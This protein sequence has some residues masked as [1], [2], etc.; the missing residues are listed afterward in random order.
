M[1]ALGRL[2][3]AALAG[4]L[5]RDEVAAEI[6]RQL[7]AFEAAWGSGPDFVDGHQ[8]VHVLPGV[9]GPLLRALTRRGGRPWLRDP[10]DALAAALWRPAPAKALTVGVLAT[11]SSD[12]HGTGKVDHDLGVNTTDPETYATLRSLMGQ[13]AGAAGR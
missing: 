8:H 6:E 9:R 10:S 4:R 11:G 7:D 13:R 1:P 3:R 2:T 5:P 12:Y